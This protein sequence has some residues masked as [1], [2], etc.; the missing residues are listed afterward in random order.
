MTTREHSPE[1]QEILR[2]LTVR[3]ILLGRS[4]RAVAAIAGTRQAVISDLELGKRVP[5]AE[6]LIRLAAGYGL[7]LALV[8]QEQV[9]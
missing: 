2:Q 9:R 6:V 8:P 1:W 3:R 7:R 4:Q 5:T